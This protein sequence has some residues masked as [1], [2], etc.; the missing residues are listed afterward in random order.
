MKHQTLIKSACTLIITAA[1]FFPHT[2][3]GNTIDPELFEKFA[4]YEKGD[5]E[6]PVRM[7]D[8]LIRTATAETLPLIEEKLIAVV[9]SP[10]STTDA[11]RH[12]CRQLSYVG[13]QATAESLV[14]RI[15]D[16]KVSHYIRY[17]LE[18][19]PSPAVDRAL[20]SAL[21]E[22]SG[23]LR[24]GMIS[25][26]A[27]RSTAEA[28]RPL[29]SL[30]ASD[31]NEIAEAAIKA[32]GRIGSREAAR[33]LSAV[34][35]K[36][37]HQLLRADAL[38]LSAD[39]M[40]A[41]GE[42]VAVSIYE[43]MLQRPVST[44]IQIA[45]LIGIAQADG[46][47]AL[48]HVIEYLNAE[49]PQLRAAAGRSLADHMPGEA[50]TSAIGE[51]LGSLPPGTQVVVINAIVERNDEASVATLRRALASDHTAVRQAALEG[52]GAIGD[53][54]VIPWLVDAA[55]AGGDEGRTART[56]LA[57]LRGDEVIDALINLTQRDE[58]DKRALAV[59]ILQ[60]RGERTSAPV[61]SSLLKDDEAAVRRATIR[62]LTELGTMDEI[63][64]IIQQLQ[65][66]DDSGERRGMSRAISS[67]L[68]RAEQPEL[69]L[70]QI[71]NALVET[72]V[73]VQEELLP[74]LRHV[75]TSQ[76]LQAASSYLESDQTSMRRAAIRVLSDWPTDE[77]MD[78]LLE[79]AQKDTDE[80]NRALA[81]RGYTQAIGRSNLSNEQKA[82]KF[83][84]ILE[85][86]PSVE[87]I[88]FVLGALI[89]SPSPQLLPVVEEYL[90]VEEVRNEAL[91]SY[92]GLAERIRDADIE[93]AVSAARRILES[94]DN[95][96]LQRRAR[97]II[98]HA[99]RYEGFITVWLLAGPYTDGDKRGTPLM[100]TEFAPEKDDA[101]VEWRE[102][103]TVDGWHVNLGQLI[104]GN[105]RA[106]YLKAQVFS[107]TD[108]RVRLELGSDDQIIAWLNDEI[109][110]RHDVA[111]GVEPAQDIVE[112]DLREGW[113]DLMLKIGQVGGGWGACARFRALD[114]TSLE[115]FRYRAQ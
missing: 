29:A 19:N 53:V 40:A 70:P 86:E 42:E 49:N 112:V 13:G 90:D 25:S 31:D 115:G 58:A 34:E 82:G 103:T 87:I 85:M 24:L 65:S 37:E 68:S 83:A 16:E 22:T 33:V 51:R 55:L 35:L 15:T 105:N 108:Q 94:T 46:E 6:A 18:S 69:A 114:G 71:L 111:R 106:A 17:A 38:L 12:A 110:H 109:V 54:S 95:E 84:A 4:V 8:A 102:V 76:A 92:I 32:L 50:V 62:A 39:R 59:E 28:V 61:L 45:A 52:L 3:V 14:K 79:T 20:L 81:M 78:K 89:E 26:L 93:K 63:P 73:D 43:A 67:I 27:A 104:G 9:L 7:I 80:G 60:A 11:I 74:V 1:V 100:D 36:S 97:A 96:D 44:G 10:D 107:P 23:E 88:R 30:A 64:A 77:A 72:S 21:R 66:S 41:A 91:L 75:G 56:S 113:N 5:S 2:S 48:P 99:E 101:E 57:A 47:R 98:E